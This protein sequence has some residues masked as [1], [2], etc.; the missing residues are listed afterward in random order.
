VGLDGAKVVGSVGLL[1][2]GTCGILR[3]MFVHV[4]FRGHA[5]GLAQALLEALL[6]HAREKGLGAVTLGTQEHLG[7]A[8]R[9]Y[10]RNG[11]RAIDPA[12]LPAG[13][14][15]MKVDTHFYTLDLR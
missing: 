8:R 10:E 5:T 7:A 6:G 13:F 11:F 15:R 2:A 9:F 4:D 1:D 3:K 14:L 12:E